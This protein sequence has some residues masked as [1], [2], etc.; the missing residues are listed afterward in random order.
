LLIWAKLLK[1]ATQRGESIKKGSE[2]VII[3]ALA[4]GGDGG[5][6]HFPRT[7][8]ASSVLLFSFHNKCENFVQAWYRR[9]IPAPK[10]VSL[11]S[12]I[13]WAAQLTGS[14]IPSTHDPPQLPSAQHSQQSHNTIANNQDRLLVSIEDHKVLK[15][16]GLKKGHS[17]TGKTMSF[18]DWWV[19]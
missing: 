3:A 7:K 1:K 18:S 11:V 17:M 12:T 6:Y 10:A 4:V 5:L 8:T 9:A 15:Q 16:D 14:H 19:V 2:V 13:A